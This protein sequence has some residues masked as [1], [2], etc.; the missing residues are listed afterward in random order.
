MSAMPPE[1]LQ[2]MPTERLGGAQIETHIRPWLIGQGLLSDRLRSVGGE[3]YALKVAYEYTASLSPIQRDDLG[4]QAGAGLFREVCMQV[5]GKTWV[6]AQT[7]IP[8]DTLN[9]F[10]WLAELGEAPIGQV[11]AGISGLERRPYEFVKIPLS[12]A[13]A[14][15]ALEWIDEQPEWFW[16]RRALYRLRGAP[17]LVQEL[18]CPGIG[19]AGTRP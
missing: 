10:P 14:R 15:H 3:G 2:W 16:A 1:S 12:H 13:L 8:D 17:V 5:G 18:F 6:Y 19:H 11:M 4:T 9:L 7:I